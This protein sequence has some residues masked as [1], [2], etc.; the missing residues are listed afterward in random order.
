VLEIRKN[1]TMTKNLVMVLSGAIMGQ[2]HDG[3]PTIKQRI[4]VRP[5]CIRSLSKHMGEDYE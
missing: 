3:G 1:T 4:L 2:V 5:L